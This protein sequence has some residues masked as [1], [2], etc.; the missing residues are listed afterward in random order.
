MQICEIAA[1]Q[2][3]PGEAEC[4]LI[5]YRYKE[6]PP[7]LK[8]TLLPSPIPPSVLISNHFEPHLSAAVLRK[9]HL[10]ASFHTLSEPHLSSTPQQHHGSHKLPTIL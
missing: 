3:G 7:L 10:L 5:S 8:P 1:K 2:E 4:V 9:L 6:Q